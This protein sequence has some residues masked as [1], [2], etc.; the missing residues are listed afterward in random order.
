MTGDGTN[1]A[2]ALAQA[3]VGVAM[4]TGTRPPR[5]P[6][7]WSTSTPT[8]P[9]SS[10]SWR[11][12]SSC[13]SRAARSRRS[14]SPTTWPSTSPSSRRCS[15]SRSRSS[16]GLNVMR[17]HSPNSAILSAVIFNAIIIVLLIPLALRG[18]KFRAIPRRRAAPLQP[19]R[20]RPGRR[21]R[22]V[23]R[24]QAHR[25]DPRGPAPHDLETDDDETLSQHRDPHDDPH[26]DPARPVYPLAITGIAQVVFPGAA[27]G[28]LVK[29]NGKV[30]GSSPH[31]PGLHGGE[32]LP[33][34]ALGGRRR[35]RRDGLVGFQ[36]RAD[37]QRPDRPGAGRR[38]RADRREPRP[39]LD[40]VP[41]D[42]VTASGS[43]LDPDITVANARAQAPRVAAARGLTRRRPAPDRGAHGGAQLGFLGEPRV[44]VLEL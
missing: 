32:V 15:W 23:H 1:D 11:S 4:N 21:H 24:H 22:A 28:S 26:G 6:A 38:A 43:G 10:R 8:P 2:P 13:S 16:H 44:N 18:V 40:A 29:V 7:T 17:L 12:A 41:V 39:R 30:V 42:M 3:D 25:H 34:A 20:L 36:S 5:K 35:L 37:Q 19:A 14:A 27:D 33:P 31:R 9:S